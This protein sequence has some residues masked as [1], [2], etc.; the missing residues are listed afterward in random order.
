[1]IKDNLILISG[2]SATGKSLSLMSLDDPG[3]VIYLNCEGKKLP[4]KSGFREYIVTDPMQIYSAMDKA[5]SMDDVHTIAIDS[6]T[7]L[8]DMY[9]TMY[10]LKATNTMKAWGDFSQYFKRLIFKHVAGS[11]KNIIFTAHTLDQLNETEM[12]M[13]TYVPIKGALK[14]NGIESYFSTVISSKKVPIKMLESMESPLLTITEEEEMLGYKHV[15]QTKLTKAT[16]NERIRSPLKMWD[17]S[18]TFI[19]N[20]AQN[21]IDKLHSYYS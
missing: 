19:D 7:Y 14:N 15:Y 6:V 17:V 1:M 9:E 10:V 16:V 20:N 18:E 13:E 2:K 12:V 5:N 8:M 11:Q 21:V 4:F 3:G